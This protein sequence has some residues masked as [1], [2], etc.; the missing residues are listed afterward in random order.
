M[1]YAALSASEIYNVSITS[2]PR[3]VGATSR[4]SPTSTTE[5]DGVI[6]I[7][8]RRECAAPEDWLA[9]REIIVGLYIGQN[10]TL[11]EV[12]ADMLELYNFDA[13]VRMYKQRLRDWH[14]FKNVT[15]KRLK[16]IMQS[17]LAAQHTGVMPEMDPSLAEQVFRY[18][19]RNRDMRRSADLERLNV[20]LKPY[21]RDGVKG[22]SARGKSS[23][24]VPTMKLGGRRRSRPSSHPAIPAMPW[25]PGL[26]M[27]EN[28]P[29]DMT[30]LLHAFVNEEFQTPQ[31]AYPYS[32][33][34]IT[35]PPMSGHT[36]QW[37]PEGT[38][39]SPSLA[40]QMAP[41]F[42]VTPDLDEA[43]LDF[44]IR[45]RY[46]HMLLDDG[47]VELA[48]YVVRQCLNSLSVCLQD[49]PD[50]DS[51]AT[52]TVLLYALSAAL[53]MA[54]NFDHLQVLHD[55]FAHINLVCAGQHPTM[56]QIADRLPL[57][58]RRHQIGTLDVTRKMISRAAFG[59]LS[60]GYQVYSWAV[61]I[62]IRQ[63]NAETKLGELY[64]LSNSP[65]VTRSAYL[66]M[67][68]DARIGAA[69]CD[70]PL[71]AQQQGIWNPTN[72]YT[73]LFLNWEQPVQGKK[74]FVSLSYMAGRVRD[75]KVAGNFGLAERMARD[76]ANF[77][78]MGWGPNDA[79]T[80]KFQEDADSIMKTASLEP[81]A[82]PPPGSASVAI[83]VP[84]SLPP[85]QHA[86]AHHEMV[87]GL[88][89]MAALSIRSNVGTLVG[90]PVGSST[91]WGQAPL[92]PPTTTTTA[93][94]TQSQ[95]PEATLPAV[96][97]SG[98]NGSSGVHM[99]GGYI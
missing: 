63:E 90:T 96:W 50:R 62:S 92:S 42:E 67:W 59:Q 26:S 21:L 24:S 65:S 47:L 86:P 32:P 39:H 81:T 53:E 14:A 69:V 52:T 13:T 38:G 70:A 19:K 3:E 72:E 10:K 75:H 51:R 89:Q 9:Y 4:S 1:P 18:A 40:S 35:P 85:V 95:Y 15:Q 23:S 88:S 94:T 98:D 60:A 29:D 30:Q 58:E 27:A 33:P 78:E 46:A 16:Y 8:S 48:M 17:A 76:T 73:S 44:T 49:S 55:L 77:V 87:H 2:H 84:V 64:A 80:R 41:P 7:A 12:R 82:Q 97:P 71:A 28:L 54:V 74:I 56:A 37:H 43:M 57:L 34:P 93:A 61:D 20:I 25:S 66:T 5:N 79:V 99:Y 68:M 45:L 6:T 22:R 31:Y 11:E 36:A 83:P 91:V